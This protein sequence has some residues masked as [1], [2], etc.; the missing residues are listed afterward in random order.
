MPLKSFV[1]DTINKLNYNYPKNGEFN[2]VIIG[3]GCSGLYSAYRLNKA[4]Q[5]SIGLFDLSE[6]ISGG[7]K[8]F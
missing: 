3:A 1:N 5:E 6:R 2:T 4:G 8:S 7:L